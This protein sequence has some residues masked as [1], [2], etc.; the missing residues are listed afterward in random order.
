M[1]TRY[2]VVG[3]VNVNIIDACLGRTADGGRN[4][5]KADPSL[6]MSKVK[7]HILS[8]LFHPLYIGSDSYRRR[9]LDYHVYQI[10]STTKQNETSPHTLLLSTPSDYNYKSYKQTKNEVSLIFVVVLGFPIG[11]CL[12]L[13]CCLG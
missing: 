13:Q 10:R 3:Y 4:N 12:A 5:E 6:R 11:G 9:R 2:Y 7:E 1:Y 8:S